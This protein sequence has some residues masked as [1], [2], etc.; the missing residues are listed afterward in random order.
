MT[1]HLHAVLPSQMA[2]NFCLKRHKFQHVNIEFEMGAA[3]AKKD[4]AACVCVSC[5]SP[6]S[7]GL[8]RSLIGVIRTLVPR[9]LP[10]IWALPLPCG[11]LAALDHTTYPQCGYLAIVENTGSTD[12]T[13]PL[14]CVFT[15]F[16]C[17][18]RVEVPNRPALMPVLRC[19][20][21]GTGTFTGTCPYRHLCTHKAMI[22]RFE[23]CAALYAT[24]KI[25]GSGARMVCGSSC[26]SSQPL[27]LKSFQK[28][29][30]RSMIVD[31]SMQ[32]KG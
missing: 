23:R 3:L 12:G 19:R 17:L 32:P 22:S 6:T 29:V 25:V 2:G 21:R 4:G 14:R 16:V 8:A 9:W 13:H 28:G 30:V 31:G 20:R 18:R 26:R 11:G 15:Y 27:D 1:Q 24:L 5:G 7:A 10:R